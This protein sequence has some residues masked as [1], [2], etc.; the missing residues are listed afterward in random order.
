VPPF[1]P[2]FPGATIPVTVPPAYNPYTKITAWVSGLELSL[3][4]SY[5]FDTPS[6][7][8]IAAKF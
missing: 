4:W 6:A 5:K 2:F 3:S 1:P 7:L 8:P